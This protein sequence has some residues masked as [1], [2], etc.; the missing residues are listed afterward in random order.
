MPHGVLPGHPWCVPPVP[1]HLPLSLLAHP[2]EGV[3]QLLLLPLHIPLGLPGRCHLLGHL[4]ILVTA[5]REL[6]D[7]QRQGPWLGKGMPGGVSGSPPSAAGQRGSAP[8]RCTS[9]SACCSAARW[10]V[11]ALPH[12]Q[13]RRGE[14]PEP[15]PR[16][17]P[18]PQ[19]G[20]W[21]SPLTF[22]LRQAPLRLLS[23]LPLLL[24]LLQLCA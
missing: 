15:P 3:L 4:R 10:P 19:A 22:N 11:P 17:S 14:H 1:T 2:L 5:E 20:C 18:P 9:P 7:P 16:G 13:G 12:T 6:S 8:A 21:L 24:Q 23:V